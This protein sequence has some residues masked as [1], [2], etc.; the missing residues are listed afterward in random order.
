MA[1]STTPQASR[2]LDH[3]L[4]PHPLLEISNNREFRCNGCNTLGQGRRY[5]CSGCDFD[6]HERCA[7]CPATLSSHLHPSHP[8]D[9]V[10]LSLGRVCDLCREEVRGLYYRCE[11]CGF[12]IHPLCTD[13]PAIPPQASRTLNH[14]SHPHPLLEIYINQKF[15]C[16]GC[17]TLG[18]GRR[19]RC[20]GCDFDLHERCATC[21]ATLSSHLHPSHPLDL[22]SLSLGRVCDLCREEVR[23]LYYRCEPCGF[24]IHPLC[25]D[26]QA[27]PPQ[28]SRT[29]NHG[30]HLHPLLEIYINQKFGCDGCNTLGQGRRYRCSGCDFD[31]HERCATCPATLS[32]HLHPSHPLDLVSLSLGRVCDLCRE[33]VRG[34]YYRCEP[35]GFDIHPLCTDLPATVEHAMHPHQLLTLSRGEPRK[36]A[37]CQQVCDSWRYTSHCNGCPVDVHLKCAFQEPAQGSRT[38]TGPGSPHHHGS[39][40]KKIYSFLAETAVKATINYFTENF[41]S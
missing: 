31:L 36:C 3:G 12:D 22:V 41:S 8:L 4:H 5:R 40:R 13:L 33:E 14:G 23:G 17:N 37:V 10:C 39:R 38:G 19:Y 35:C 7:T 30:S 27:I 6:L 18:Q 15:G 29:L 25:T 24:D 28:A 32:S 16:D 1:T 26:L 9:L 11:P 21:P 2:T 34:L 20:S